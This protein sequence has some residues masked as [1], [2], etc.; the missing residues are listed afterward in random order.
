MRRRMLAAAFMAVA[1]VG[2]VVVLAQKPEPESDS[3][4]LPAPTVEA[5]PQDAIGIA[6]EPALEVAVPQVRA[7][8]AVRPPDDPMQEVEQFVTQN[9]K[10]AEDSI[11]SL[12]QEAE[13]L[14]AR[15][16]KVEAAIERWK[17]LEEAL[18]APIQNLEPIERTISEKK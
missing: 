1:L 10:R 6:Q 14:R 11:K 13:T 15:L 17:A 7:Q 16:Q 8:E 5:P 4:P 2:G 3:K 9:R 18:K 12:S